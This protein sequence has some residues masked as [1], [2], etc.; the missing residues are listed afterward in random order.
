MKKIP[1]T[2][3]RYLAQKS[4][5]RMILVV[6][7]EEGGYSITSYGRRHSEGEAAKVLGAKI[8]E[9][10]ED[11]SLATMAPPED[12]TS[13]RSVDQQVQTLTELLAQ[14][15]GGHGGDACPL[16]YGDDCVRCRVAGEA[17][18]ILHPQ[19]DRKEEARK[20]KAAEPPPPVVPTGPCSED[21]CDAAAATNGLCL[22]HS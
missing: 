10:F 9:Q 6:A 2:S 14:A 19:A 8:G 1:E 17:T 16:G 13:P 4:G 22:K 20:K 15:V 11:G 5:A 21:G 12:G 3:A 18:A 7:I